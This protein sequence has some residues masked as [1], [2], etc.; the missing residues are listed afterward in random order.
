[1]SIWG[2]NWK[3]TVERIV[4][5]PF[6]AKTGIPVEFEVGGTIDRLAKA[7]VAKGNPLV[8]LNFTTTHVAR[9]YISDGLYAPLDMAK[10]PNA[11]EA[12]REALRSEYHIGSWAYV[13]TVVYRPDLVKEDITR[14]SDL[15]KPSL[16]GKIALPDFD[17]SH[18][19]TIAALMEG[20]NELTWEKGQERL[21]QLKP[22]LVAFYSTDAQSQ[23]LMKTGQAPV[24]VMLTVN[25]YHLQEQGIA[26]KLVQPADYP[27]I[28]GIDTMAVMAGTKRVDAA[29]QFINM[30]LS[31]EI[32]SQLVESLRARPGQR[33]RGGAREAQGPAGDL[34][35]TGRVEGPRLHHERR[36]ARQDAPG[37]AGVVHREYRQ[38]VRLLLA[39][40]LGVLAIFAVAL[41]ALFQYSVVAFIPGS[42]QTGELTLA[43][44]RSVIS[45]QYLGY[46]WD[47]VALSLATT[48]LTLVASYPVAY[49][50][51]RAP[52][53]AVRSWLLVLTL[54]PFFTGA[55]VRTYA[56]ILV[57]GNTVVTWPIPLLFTERGV[58][59]GLVH[60][61]MPT[62]ILLLAAAISHVDPALERAAASLGATPARVFRRVTLPLSMPGIVSGSLVVFAWTLSAFPTPELLGGGRVKMIAN[63]VK[64]LA[65]DS[66]NWPGAAA[67]AV[68]ALALTLVLMGG[69]GRLAAGHEAE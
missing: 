53:R 31:K 11:K 7:R 47:T 29:H 33:G 68:V 6:T 30:V 20:G 57:L 63:A 40:A 67:F 51:A 36:G 32:Q 26:V 46:V 66:F 10:L 50:L 17:P 5:K 65:L 61:S 14:W 22:S 21:R 2:G 38:E 4:A 23:D 15:W 27:G 34:H 52:S 35:D 39:P 25:A 42:L 18:I 54:A 8:D 13:Y 45:P 44:F 49:A 48:A 69:L 64:D 28:V 12:A 16:K 60:F 1:M 19:I 41:G 59:I 24:Q 62:M 37:V 58:L 56:W 3:D 55:I 9:L 43:N